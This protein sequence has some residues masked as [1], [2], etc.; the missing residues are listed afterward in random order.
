MTWRSGRMPSVAVYFVA[1]ESIAFC[2]ARRMNSGV[3]KSGSPAPRSS[4]SRP[5]AFSA[6]ARLATASVADSLMWET[7]ADGANDSASVVVT[8]YVIPS[9]LAALSMNTLFVLPLDPSSVPTFMTP[10]V[11]QRVLVLTPDA[12]TAVMIASLLGRDD[13]LAA[14]SVN[15][16]S[17][18]TPPA[19]VIGPPE[20]ISGLMTRSRLKLDGVTTLVLAWVGASPALEAVLVD[21]PKDAARTIVAT[22]ATPEVEALV[23]RYARRPRRVPGAPPIAPL[24]N[25][26]YVNV[27]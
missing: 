20:V 22:T 19:I 6:R 10:V 7:F 14:T 13:V 12:E 21:V 23:E 8:M 5:A 11:G 24:P 2:A 27:A 18:V 15:R 4:T 9:S 25:T 17:R 1:P 26:R 3:S 16:A